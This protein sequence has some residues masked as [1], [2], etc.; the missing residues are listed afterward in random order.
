MVRSITVNDFL[1]EATAKGVIIDVRTPA[2]YA[3]GH[4][5][6]AINIPL[7]TNEE[8]VV[9]GTLYIKVGRE[10]AI[11]KGLEFVGVRMADMVR[12]AKRIAQGSPVYLYCWR[13]GMRSS[14][15]AWLFSTAGLK[16]SVLKGGYK[17]YRRNFE[18]LLEQN[19]WQF[20]LLSGSTGC[21]KTELLHRISDMGE[22][23]L[24]IESL[25]NHKGS[26]FGGLG[27]EQQPTTEH[28][29]NK[30]H[31]QFR[32]LTS[33]RMVWCEAE[34]MSIGSIYLPQRF[35]EIMRSGIDIRIE[36]DIEQRLDRLM[37][38]YG[39]FSAENLIESFRKITKRFGPDQT[40]IAIEHI[41][42]G[43]IRNAA[44][45]GLKYYDKCYKKT[46]DDGRDTCF[47]ADNTN[48]EQSAQKLNARVHGLQKN[49]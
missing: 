5:I 38:E 28:F 22:Q 34:S 49:K 7:F 10:E 2:E 43:E 26:A 45:M 30:L 39:S 27:Q 18:Q 32:E 15:V 36:M 13:G 16:V 37:V 23:V 25:A 35:Y 20:V 8:R 47:I 14:S 44:A 11:E 33:T 9:V 12:E 21:G 41:E 48:M 24:D 19:D 17:A 3:K 42:N 6:G 31:H 29:I 46:A 40:K 1:N 4:I